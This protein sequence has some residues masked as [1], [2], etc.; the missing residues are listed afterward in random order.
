MS[1]LKHFNFFL[2]YLPCFYTACSKA[3]VVKR[4]C[5]QTAASTKPNCV[6]GVLGLLL[7]HFQQ[8]CARQNNLDHYT[9]T[10]IRSRRVKFIQG[11]D[12][13][14]SPGSDVLIRPLVSEWQFAAELQPG[15]LDLQTFRPAD[16]Q[17][18]K[19]ADIQTCR[20][21]D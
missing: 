21:L 12:R 18:S 13:S 5:S 20:P 17:T 19:P 10:H 14:P 3:C 16:L 11:S 6:D 7:A 8:S 2:F 1:S 4:R 9:F 15:P